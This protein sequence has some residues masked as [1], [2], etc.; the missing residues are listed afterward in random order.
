MDCVDTSDLTMPKEGSTISMMQGNAGGT[1]CTTSAVEGCVTQGQIDGVDCTKT[2]ALKCS[3]GMPDNIVD[4]VVNQTTVNVLIHQPGRDE[5]CEVISLV[6][7]QEHDSIHETSN[8]ELKHISRM[9]ESGSATLSL[10]VEETKQ[11]AYE[12]A[13]DTSSS[14]KANNADEE[15]LNRT[16]THDD[17]QQLSDEE[18]QTVRQ[19]R[20]KPIFQFVFDGNSILTTIQPDCSQ[21]STADLGDAEQFLARFADFIQNMKEVQPDA[22]MGGWK[23]EMFRR[24]GTQKTLDTFYT[25][26]AER[27][28]YRSKEHFTKDVLRAISDDGEKDQ[29]HERK[30]MREDGA[31]AGSFP[32]PNGKRR[33]SKRLAKVEK[34]KVHAKIVKPKTRSR[35][36]TLPSQL[37]EKQELEQAKLLA[38]RKLPDVQLFAKLLRTSK[39]ILVVL[40]AGV[41]TS[42]GLPDF[43]TKATGL[44]SAIANGKLGKDALPAE[45]LFHGET[46]DQDP[47][48]FYEFATKT[49]LP[50][51]EQAKPTLTHQFVSLLANHHDKL[52]RCYTQNVDGLEKIAGLEE[53]DLVLCH[54][55]M[56]AARCM[57]C[58]Q[59][60]TH[61]YWWQAKSVANKGVP[62][63]EQAGCNGDLK[64]EMIFFGDQVSGKVD[65]FVQRDVKKCD[66][67]VVI[68]TSLSVQPV[69]EILASVPDEVPK[70]WINRLKPS[71][72]L[73]STFAVTLN[74]ECDEQILKTMRI[75]RWAK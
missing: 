17:E 66:L 11:R 31:G 25:L 10:Y 9:S 54:G 61:P 68:G 8:F 3:S 38:K 21:G 72:E 2:V 59:K 75:L 6:V 70:V 55:T 34:E 53:K 23:M 71:S 26:E 40:G 15:D 13:S 4:N 33:L 65:L 16:E 51:A 49:F 29:R 48:P 36:G 19:Q 64:P 5:N 18:K 39:N 35:T 28:T 7:Q 27:R 1:V 50:L 44:Y 43:R 56:R 32:T 45:L 73:E 47:V 63:C 12:E 60:V 67:V 46:F 20:R 37:K 30:R 52:L 69:S 14:F 42:A 22:V 74:G 57:K 58:K 24:K 41:S 62:E